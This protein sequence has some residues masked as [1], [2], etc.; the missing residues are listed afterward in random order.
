MAQEQVWK[1][2]LDLIDQAKKHQQLQN[3][4]RL[5]NKIY[6]QLKENPEL[7]RSKA[8]EEAR[9]VHKLAK[10]VMRDRH[11]QIAFLRFNA[12]PEWLLCAKTTSEHNVVPSVL[13][14]FIERFP[15]YIILIHDRRTQKNYLDTRRTDICLENLN[16]NQPYSSLIVLLRE[17]L[18][19]QLNILDFVEDFNP[20]VWNIH[21]DAQFV[22]ERRN[23]KLAQGF[24]PQY[25]AKKFPEIHRDIQLINSGRKVKRIDEFLEKEEEK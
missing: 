7:I 1:E 11:Q 3:N 16:L 22:K 20:D 13:E 25:L 5:L 18:N 2:A 6:T 8:T 19:R 21:Y 10:G 14:H 12:Y 9:L 24:M 17:E 4:E 23:R 15:Q